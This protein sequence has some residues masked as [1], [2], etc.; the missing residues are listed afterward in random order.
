MERWPTSSP[1]DLGQ[2]ARGPLAWLAAALL[3]SLVPI[4]AL[5]APPASLSGHMAFHIVSMNFLAPLAALAVLQAGHRAAVL[6]RLKASLPAAS[7]VQLALL[8]GSHLPDVLPS[9]VHGSAVGAI[10]QAL[11]LASALWFW[12]A[13]FGQVGVHRWR[14]LAALLVSGKLFC[15]L[16]VLLVFAPR[17]LYLSYGQLH[18][19]I[20]HIDALAD[21]QLAGLLMVLACPLSYVLA[22]VVIAARWVMGMADAGGRASAV[23]T[24]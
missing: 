22:G 8:W 7:I 20:G 9:L 1:T 15:L 14:A 18:V 13:T 4:V 11:L 12:L 5:L 17:P 21:Q 24:A 6:D 3:L 10:A 23:R 2:P 19:G 16:G